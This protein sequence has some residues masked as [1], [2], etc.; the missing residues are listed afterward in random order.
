MGWGVSGGGGLAWSEGGGST[1]GQGEQL[2]QEYMA[3][4]QG[5]L[6]TLV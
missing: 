5:T 1:L 2:F 4:T 3:L 6:K